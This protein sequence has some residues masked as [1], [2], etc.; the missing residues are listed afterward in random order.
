MMGMLTVG[1]APPE[2]DD[3]THDTAIGEEEESDE[4][5]VHFPVS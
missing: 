4:E 1:K 5:L 3:I 2:L